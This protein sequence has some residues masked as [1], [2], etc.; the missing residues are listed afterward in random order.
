MR[1]ITVRFLVSRIKGC[2]T[3]DPLLI[4]SKVR[5]LIM[6]CPPVRLSLSHVYA[7][8]MFIRA[9]IATA[10]VRSIITMPPP[11]EAA[12]LTTLQAI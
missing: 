12:L 8:F 6:R 9:L 7:G 4:H 2:S 1:R 3:Y 11:P 5:P 10:T